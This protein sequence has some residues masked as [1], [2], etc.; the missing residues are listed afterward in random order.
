IGGVRLDEVAGA[1]RAGVVDADDAADPGGGLGDHVEDVGLDPIAGHDE[2]DAGTLQARIEG[3]QHLAPLLGGPGRRSRDLV[4]GRH[5]SPAAPGIAA[6]AMLVDSR[7]DHFRRRAGFAPK[8]KWSATRASM[9]GSAVAKRGKALSLRPLY[10]PVRSA[11][12]SG[13]PLIGKRM[14]SATHMLRTGRRGALFEFQMALRDL[15]SS[16][17]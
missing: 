17:E 16:A 10:P 12:A 9:E 7:I 11:P 8:R 6:A 2:P 5:A 14:D 3:A 1:L 13:E 15:R 4:D